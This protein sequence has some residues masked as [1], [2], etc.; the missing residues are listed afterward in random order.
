MLQQLIPYAGM[1][2]SAS[3]AEIQIFIWFPW[4]TERMN[5][6]PKERNVKG[7]SDKYQ[8][9]LNLDKKTFFSK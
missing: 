7:K 3:V 4:V 6:E 5:L 8:L 9:V 2:V 1:N